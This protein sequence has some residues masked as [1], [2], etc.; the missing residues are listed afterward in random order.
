MFECNKKVYI[1]LYFIYDQQT[2]SSQ[3]KY[4]TIN[5]SDLS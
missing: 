2:V 1:I 4:F 3:L 5:S